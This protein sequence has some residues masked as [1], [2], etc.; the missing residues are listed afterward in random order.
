MKSAHARFSALIVKHQKSKQAAR[1][2]SD[3]EEEYSEIVQ[4]LDDLAE[5]QGVAVEQQRMKEER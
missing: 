4:L 5:E 3:I 1:N 2:T